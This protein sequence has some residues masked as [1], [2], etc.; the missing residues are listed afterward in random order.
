MIPYATKLHMLWKCF[1]LL[2]MP[3]KLLSRRT[4]SDLQV[5]SI[6]CVH[7]HVQWWCQP[8]LFLKKKKEKKCGCIKIE[9]IKYRTYK[10]KVG[11]NL[12]LRHHWNTILEQ[13]NAAY[14]TQVSM[15]L[16]VAFFPLSSHWLPSLK[17]NLITLLDPYSGLTLL[18]SWQFRIPLI[19]YLL[20]VLNG[21]SV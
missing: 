15:G 16:R 14:A 11:E 12:S 7:L 3:K 20:S 13:I 17:Y 8:F 9:R 5:S 2:E 1:Y 19:G 21:V 4:D 10:A 6:R 18:C